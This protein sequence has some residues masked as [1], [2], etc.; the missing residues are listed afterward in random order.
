M[1]H[2][3]HSTVS[4]DVVSKQF[5]LVLVGPF[6]LEFSTAFVENKVMVKY[7]S[8]KCRH[9][10][11]R[12][13][14]YT[15]VV[16][17]AAFKPDAVMYKKRTM[18]V[19]KPGESLQFSSQN[20]HEPIGV[21]L[22]D[23]IPC[24]LDVVCVGNVEVSNTTDVIMDNIIDNMDALCDLDIICSGGNV[25]K[26]HKVLLARQSNVFNTMFTSPGFKQVDQI[27]IDDAD[28]ASVKRMV[29][30]VTS[31]VVPTVIVSDFDFVVL[32][33]KYGFS[34]I[35]DSWEYEARMKMG[36]ENVVSVMR[37]A[38]TVN[39]PKLNTHAMRFIKSKQSVR[40]VNDLTKDEMFQ[41]LSL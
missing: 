21:D 26:T 9:G 6:I 4:F 29:D 25:I 41:I 11:V 14:D 3:Y 38:S 31:G 28:Y 20:N 36:P 22:G 34:K 27:T 17:L 32:C 37:V 16:T 39:K 23:K 1:A 30:M 7:K 12:R 19:N 18:N 10:E 5:P 24:V 2:V 33:D 15:I 8:F 40:F 13:S 35:V